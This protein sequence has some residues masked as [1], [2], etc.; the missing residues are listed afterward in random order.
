[1][2]DTTT[3]RRTPARAPSSWRLRDAAMKK[4]VAGFC[5]FVGHEAASTMD[6]TPASAS[7]RPS[8]VTTS[9][10]VARDIGTT[11]WPASSTTSTTWRPTLPVA[12]AT[13]TFLRSVMTVS[14]FTSVQQDDERQ[15]CEGTAL[16]GDAV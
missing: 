2:I 9:T 3:I 6:S 5:S 14:L 7:L 8:P 4:S 10:P 12:A 13:A 11:S 16:R 15:T 1:M